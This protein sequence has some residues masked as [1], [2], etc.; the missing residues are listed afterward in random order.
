MRKLFGLLALSFACVAVSP[1]VFAQAKTEVPPVVPGAKPVTID[2]VKV[3]GKAL[4]GNLDGY[5]A[6]RDVLVFLPPS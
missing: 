2:R 5:A 3:H 1:H 6:Y 4:D